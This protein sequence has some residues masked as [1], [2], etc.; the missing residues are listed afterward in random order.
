MTRVRA[1]FNT[2]GQYVWHCH[3]LEHE[4]NEMMRPYRV[5]PPQPGQPGVSGIG[6][7][8]MQPAS[9]PAYEEEEFI[10]ADEEATHVYIPF[11]VNQ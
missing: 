3:I 11:V 9:A 8:A 1:R 2:P 10:G 6:D 4:D 5:G 7:T